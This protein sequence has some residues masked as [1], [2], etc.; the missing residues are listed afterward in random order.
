MDKSMIWKLP[1]EK[2]PK[3]PLYPL[4]VTNSFPKMIWLI[5]LEERELF[6]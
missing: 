6:L 3:S 2:E 5:G 4:T 1:P